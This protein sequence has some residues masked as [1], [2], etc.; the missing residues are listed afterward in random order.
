M[1][2][3][4]KSTRQ[5]T[6]RLVVS[7]FLLAAVL[8]ALAGFEIGAAE[9]DPPA[10]YGNTPSRN[11]VSDVRGLPSNWDVETGENV[12]W[13]AKLGSQTYAGPVVHG[14]RVYVGTN[15][16]GALRE[17]IEGDKGVMLAFD[18]TNGELLWQATH[19]K[20]PAGRVNDWP[21]Q[22]I[23]STPFI[24]GDRV[25]YVSNEATVVCA[26]VEGFRD[27]ENDG[28]F[29]DEKY[30]GEMDGDIIWSLDMIGE[31]DV[32]PHNLAAG[33]PLVVDGILFT[34]TGN[35]VD[36]GHVN[37][38]SPLG[39]SFLA[40]DAT[41]GKV[42]WE[43]ADPGEN[44]LH[45]TWSNPAYGVVDGTPQV[46][47]PGGDGWLYSFE[48]K[49]GN[50]FWKFD[51]NPKDSVWELGGSGTRNNVISTPVFYKNRFYVGVGQDPEHG[52]APGHFYAIDATKEGDVTG[53]AEVFH[54]GGDEFNR[55]I[56]TAAIH[57]GLVFISDLSGFLY[58][59]DAETGEKYWTYDT[60]A[61]IWGS[62]FVADGKVYLGDE[63][64]DVV[65]LE[66]SKTKKLI[67]E[68]NMGSAVYTTPVAHDGVLYIATRSELFAIGSK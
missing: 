60:F 34:T 51:L 55:T 26:D 39:P 53:E 48:P 67:A 61:A 17:G 52:E 11:M 49:T 66:A 8:G 68:I 6:R 23:C 33:S 64:G 16:E 50:L 42:V 25:Y 28:P 24:E 4:P 7:L 32:F 58:C 3:P 5:S 19:D 18:A 45:G 43:N 22:G 29:T 56:S 63:D 14:G 40:I 31:L 30:K 47:F 20:L 46:V 65:I 62:P 27:G 44:I 2:S 59:L 54:V 38:P 57:D 12:L 37:I 21:L 9:T 35:G 36:E 15:N 1:I 41:T 10:M 13:A